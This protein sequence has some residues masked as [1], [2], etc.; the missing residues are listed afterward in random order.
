MIAWT[1]LAGLGFSVFPLKPQEKRPLGAWEKY[2]TARP[3]AE[4]LKDWAA[5][6]GLNA[7]IAT[8]AVSG[9]FVVDVD[10]SQGASAIAARG[11]PPTA[12][13]VTGKGRHHYFRHPGFPVKNSAGRIAPGVDVRG[14]GGYVCAP[15]SIH[16]SGALYRWD[17]PPAQVPVAPAPGWLINE[18]RKHQY[19][20]YLA[21]TSDAVPAPA[22]EPAPPE[23]PRHSEPG[24]YAKA[25]LDREVARLRA[26]REGTRNA[27]LN[28][29]AMVF[30]QFVAG[31]EIGEQDARTWLNDEAAAIG[32]TQAEARATIASGLKKGM[33]EPRS[34]A[35]EKKTEAPPRIPEPAGVLG[36][37]ITAAELQ[38]KRFAP[39][40]WVVPGIVVEGLTLLAGK[41]K[42]G[43]SWFALNCALAVAGGGRA[44][45]A[46]ECAEGD[47]LALMLEDNARRLQDRLRQL[48]P[49]GAWP[50]RLTFHTAWPRLGEGALE[51][52][53]AWAAAR[54]EPR[55]IL[56]DVLAAVRAA[57]NDRKSPYTDDYGALEG[58]QKFASKHRLA[59]V[60]VHHCRKAAADDDVF[61]EI[62]C[63]TGLTGAAD[64]ALVLKR[65]E[66]K[67]DFLYGRGRDLPEFE[68]AVTFD[69]TRGLWTVLGE[70]DDF[71]GDEIE[72]R[73]L[74][75]LGLSERPLALADVVAASGGAYEAVKQ[76]L[77][78]MIAAGRIRKCGRGKFAPA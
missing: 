69:K 23:P 55:L 44:L 72:R 6:P 15:G 3:S 71:R 43:K 39:I 30:G 62:S 10:T 12:S 58:L 5:R 38:G 18:L 28:I 35:R 77:Y 47:V 25:A 49:N 70:A 7:A 60:V 9:I 22:P 54:A 31:G 53:E 41:P 74:D 56:I 36:Q 61:D 65:G 48:A 8:G 13:V 75:A 32:L 33:S 73:V 24:P 1:E 68:K 59:L 51:A 26:A 4:E 45:G 29:A 2:Q 64:S 11:L 20:D 27:T 14:D 34:G 42:R 37:G 52:L 78:R 21:K 17:P 46:V 67:T 16:P 40:R 76:R 66:G 19:A 57:G 63:T 50:A